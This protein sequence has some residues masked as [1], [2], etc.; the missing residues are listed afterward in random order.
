MSKPY[1]RVSSSIGLNGTRVPLIEWNVKVTFAAQMPCF[2]NRCINDEG[3]SLKTDEGLDDVV[4]YQPF[5][6]LYRRLPPF[7]GRP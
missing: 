6:D 3:T 5:S 1:T 7:V 2:V 4:F